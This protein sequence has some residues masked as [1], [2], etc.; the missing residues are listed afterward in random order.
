MKKTNMIKS[1]RTFR[2]IYK[3]GATA[4]TPYMAFYAT[5][6]RWGKNNLG[7]T[8]NVKI[9]KAVIR[10]RIKRIIKESYRLN[11]ENVKDGYNIVI[12]SRFKMANA[13]FFDTQKSLITLLKKLELWKEC[14][15]NEVDNG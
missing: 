5:K 2:Y 10:N 4:S 15:K 3:K 9:G 14:G 7:I 8:V 12:V 1:N 6:D 11:E 13:T